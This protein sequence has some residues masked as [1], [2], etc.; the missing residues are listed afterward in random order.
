MNTFKIPQILKL[1]PGARFI[2]IYRDG[3][4]VIFSYMKKEYEKISANR[5]IYR[6]QGYDYNREELLKIM[7]KSWVDHMDEVER[8]KKE[9][10]MEGRIF[11]LAYE[12]FCDAPESALHGLYDFLGLDRR[13]S[14]IDNLPQIGSRNYKFQEQLTPGQVQE[15]TGIMAKALKKKG[16]LK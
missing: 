4:A 5:Q 12:S 11:D 3:R 15:V 1:F 13:D 14:G 10:E 9:L 8:Q 2:H 16:Y 7:A 6:G